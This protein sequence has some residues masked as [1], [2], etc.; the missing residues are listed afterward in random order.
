MRDLD[1]NGTIDRK[2]LTFSTKK[3]L[4]RHSCTIVIPYFIFQT[5]EWRK[6]HRIASQ[7][8]KKASGGM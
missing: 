7:H 4:R 6:G 8:C 2:S 3:A 5:H 1:L